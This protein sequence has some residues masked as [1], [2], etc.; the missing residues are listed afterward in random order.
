M[1]YGNKQF[2]PNPK[3]VYWKQC[4]A[5]LI[6]YIPS[7]IACLIIVNTPCG[8]KYSIQGSKHE[9]NNFQFNIAI[10]VIITE[11]I[12]STFL[13]FYVTCSK[14]IGTCAECCI[15]KEP[16]PERLGSQTTSK[17]CIVDKA[18]SSSFI[19]SEYTTKKTKDT[20]LTYHKKT[21]FIMRYWIVLI[22][23]VSPILICPFLIYFGQ[24]TEGRLNL[25]WNSTSKVIEC[26]VISKHNQDTATYG[27]LLLGE[28][29]VGP[30]PPTLI[31]VVSI[32]HLA[33]LS[34][35]DLTRYNN[36]RTI[37][38]VEE[39]GE[40]EQRPSS[41]L[42]NAIKEMLDNPSGPVLY[43]LRNVTT[44]KFLVDKLRPHKNQ[45]ACFDS[46]DPFID[47]DEKSKSKCKCQPGG[48]YEPPV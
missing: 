27:T 14:L 2:L 5:S 19:V 6:C 41:P 33:G 20:K 47:A 17:K 16:K 31:P 40:N 37:L 29:Y 48:C 38:I 36:A 46:N 39:S 9:M 26:T 18:F 21:Q 23:A 1:S 30:I 28:N 4:I 45:F 3:K 12:L 13:S 15:S 44:A 22:T 10:T 11:G 7:L 25:H 42:P 43:L 34:K 32:C 35:E 24:T 8:E